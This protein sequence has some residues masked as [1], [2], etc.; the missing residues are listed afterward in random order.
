MACYRNGV[1]TDV[2]ISGPTP[3]DKYYGDGNWSRKNKCD[4]GGNQPWSND[5]EWRGH[6]NANK[7][8]NCNYWV[9]EENINEMNGMEVATSQEIINLY[10]GDILT[11]IK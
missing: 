9:N 6:M 11:Q 1:G 7:V 2:G 4:G 5:F 8:T 10:G 3:S